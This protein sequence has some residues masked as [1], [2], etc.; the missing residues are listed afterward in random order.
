MS[1][2]RRRGRPQGSKSSPHAVVDVTP[3]LCPHCGQTTQRQVIRIIR[4]GQ[5]DGQAPN[6]Q[7]R[8]HIIWR[9]VRCGECGGY[10]VEAEHVFQGMER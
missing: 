6:G 3:P 9:R 8:S 5:H 4:Q 7:P 10:F 1:D 2:K